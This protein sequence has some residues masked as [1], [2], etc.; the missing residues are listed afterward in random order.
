MGNNG[1]IFFF[2]EFI[3]DLHLVSL[4]L[5][6]DSVT[7]AIAVLVENHA[8]VTLII[9]NEKLVRSAV[10]IPVLRNDRHK[11]PLRVVY[12]CRNSSCGKLL[13]AV[14]QWLFLPRC[15]LRVEREFPAAPCKLR[16]V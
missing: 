7:D 6:S 11:I 15:S 13:Q 5:Y 3:F 1:G 10:Y 14:R 4:H 16:C 9:R 2:P 12:G 8:V